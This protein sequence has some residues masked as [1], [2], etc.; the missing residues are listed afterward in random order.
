MS[1]RS[2]RDLP[3]VSALLAQESLGPWLARSRPTVLSA[4]R[5]A[6]DESRAALLRGEPA[7]VSVEEI[8]RRV[9][10]SLASDSP[11]LRP[12]L[13]ATGVLLHTGLGRAPMAREAVEAVASVAG[14]YSNLE[15]D[16]ESGERGD[17]TSGVAELLRRLTGARGRRG[18]EQQRGG[19]RAGV[20][21]PRQ[22]PG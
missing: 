3:P 18:G 1:E 22:W 16:L 4:I 8:A 6:L 13:N 14:G 21:G 12:V 11:R 2:P 10:I 20:A 19:H 7:A 15:F 9:L 17:R 5:G